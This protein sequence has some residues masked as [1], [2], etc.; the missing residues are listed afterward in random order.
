[1]SN[2]DEPPASRHIKTSTR[3]A[4][5]MAKPAVAPMARP[6]STSERL[7]FSS[8]LL[9]GGGAVFVGWGWDGMEQRTKKDGGRQVKGWVVAPEGVGGRHLSKKDWT[10][11]CVCLVCRGGF[12]RV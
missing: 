7:V 6:P 10:R 8:I 1:M 2:P 4:P 12:C 3:N 5:A 11:L 9:V